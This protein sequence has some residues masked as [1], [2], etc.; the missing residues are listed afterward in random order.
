V[1]VDSLEQLSAAF[2]EWRTGK[3]HLRE[4]VP[5]ELL[6]KARRMAKTYG[7]NRVARALK[8]DRR[9]LE[10][11]QTAAREEG[12]TG[13]AMTPSYS[14]VDLVE[15]AAPA[16]P[17]AELEL[18]NGI[19]LRLYVETQAVLGLLSSVCGAGGGR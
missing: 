2:G 5:E 19:K 13:P 4:R 7:V 18:P 6:R 17:L 10:G 9:R 16:R 3:R 8:V 11:P 1:T 14:R 15:V 12:G